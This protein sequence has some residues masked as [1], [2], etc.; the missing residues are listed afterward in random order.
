MVGYGFKEA[1]GSLEADIFAFN[2]KINFCKTRIICV[3]SSIFNN[4]D[5]RDIGTFRGWEKNYEN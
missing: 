5:G 2:N 3:I 1:Y 4:I